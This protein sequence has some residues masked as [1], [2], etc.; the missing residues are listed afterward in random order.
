MRK[1]VVSIGFTK[2]EGTLDEKYVR[3]VLE[4]NGKIIVEGR[5]SLGAGSRI[6]VGGILEVCSMHNSSRMHL[7]CLDH[8]YIGKNVDVGWNATIMDSDMHPCIRIET[9]YITKPEKPVTIGDN[10]WIGTDCIILKG[11]V[12]PSGCIVGAKSVVNRVF[13]DRNTVIAGNPAIV[14]KTKI[15]RYY[16][17]GEGLDYIKKEQNKLKDNI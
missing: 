10:V 15:T 4:I 9:S 8:I 3:S 17:C 16:S 14:T 7:I 1:G 6:C 11:S 13:K 2:G 12:I 5:I